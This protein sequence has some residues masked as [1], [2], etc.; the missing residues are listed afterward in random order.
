MRPK[1][2]HLTAHE[3]E[4]LLFRAV[5]SCEANGTGTAMQMARE[6]LAT[7]A[8]CKSFADRLCQADA[9]F[10]SAVSNTWMTTSPSPG[11]DC[12]DE[13]LWSRVATGLVGEED[14]IRLLQH[15]ARCDRCGPLLKESMEQLEQAPTLEEQE[16]LLKLPSAMPAWQR[17]LAERLPPGKLTKFVKDFDLSEEPATR[18]TQGSARLLFRNI[19]LYALAAALMLSA[20]LAIFSYRLFSQ[21]QQEQ[22]ALRIL[23]QRLEQ[24]NK[25][26]ERPQQA[27]L[28]PQETSSVALYEN[29]L[30]MMQRQLQEA[31][32]RSSK[33]LEADQAVAAQLERQIQEVN[34]QVSQLEDIGMELANQKPHIAIRSFPGTSVNPAMGLFEGRSADPSFSIK[35]PSVS[36]SSLPRVISA[37][38]FPGSPQSEIV[39]P[40][41]AWA[42]RFSLQV[43]SA[44]KANAK[45][46]LLNKSSEALVVLRGITRRVGKDNVIVAIIGTDYLTEGNYILRI[47]VADL[48]SSLQYSFKVV[49]DQSKSD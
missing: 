34:T 36:V 43:P 1:N 46:E 24:V 37:S 9:L 2:M 44:I 3:L 26:P 33:Q 11:E 31:G 48:P 22:A 47:T 17:R 45:V 32:K 28:N 10:Q 40:Q 7:C 8:D 29:T 18:E 41:G 5:A 25:Q 4:S 42:V 35:L 20:V 14:A 21:L 30:H 38:F 13:S 6:H 15:A 23:T 16:T 49:F 12:V 19:Y 39:I 27:R